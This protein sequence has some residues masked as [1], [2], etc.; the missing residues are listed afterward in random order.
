MVVFNI[1][2]VLGL[3]VTCFHYFRSP[4]L[5]SQSFYIFL[6]LAPAFPLLS[7]SKGF[8][9]LLSLLFPLVLFSWYW[10]LY[11][12]LYSLY[13]VQHLFLH[14][15]SAFYFQLLLCL[16]QVLV[17]VSSFPVFPDLLLLFYFLL[18][19]LDIN[20]LLYSK[21]LVTSSNS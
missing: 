11:A 8:N 12:S 4:I 2:S 9:L 17:L 6:Y 5:Y 3:F 10:L 1:L 15:S 7:F 13:P 21:C 14:S 18:I 20:S 19:D 16:F